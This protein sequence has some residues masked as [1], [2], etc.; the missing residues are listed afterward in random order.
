MGN[1]KV[2]LFRFLVL[3]VIGLMLVSWFMPWWSIEIYE[4]GDDV[5]VIR[6]WGLE[7]NS[8]S[9]YQP[10]GDEEVLPVTLKGA[11]M[12][13]WFAPAMW[14]YLGIVVAALL[15]SLFVKRKEL[16]IWKIKSTLPSLII[17]TVGFSYIVVVVLCVIV[18]AIRTG[19]FY[20]VHLMGYTYIDLG[21]YPYQSGA[22]AGMKLGYWLS[23]AVGPLLIVLALLRNKIIG[24]K[25]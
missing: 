15:F 25:F 6:P 12:P 4:L 24:N 3:V 20:G 22:E 23:C 1:A 17:G 19:D 2:W 8:E 11:D 13:V 10:S 5:V 18:T 21:H 14:T 7:D 16:K 9:G